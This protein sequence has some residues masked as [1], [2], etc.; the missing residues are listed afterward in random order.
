MSR[1]SDQPHDNHLLAVLPEAEWA[2]CIG[3][4]VVQVDYACFR[5][6]SSMRSGD[7]FDHVYFPKSTA[8][9][10]AAVRDGRRRVRRDC[11]CRQ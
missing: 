7:R 8:S 5:G 9:R 10:F 6:R 11:D 3:P 4:H 1:I 2:S